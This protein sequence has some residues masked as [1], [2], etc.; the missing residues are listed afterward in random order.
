MTEQYALNLAK[1]QLNEALPEETHMLIDKVINSVLKKL[2]K[3]EV[4]VDEELYYGDWTRYEIYANAFQDAF[5]S[6]LEEL[7]ADDLYEPKFADALTA[8]WYDKVIDERP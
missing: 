7:S 6:L 1:S 4:S 5:I 2:K 3:F 8:M